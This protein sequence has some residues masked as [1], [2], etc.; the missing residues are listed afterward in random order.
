MGGAVPPLA[1]LFSAKWNQAGL[2]AGRTKKRFGCLT[3][4]TAHVKKEILCADNI[5][6]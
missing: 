1:E 2:V 5:Y 6:Y 3:T 4:Y